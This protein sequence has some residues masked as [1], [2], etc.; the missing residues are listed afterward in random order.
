MSLERIEDDSQQRSGIR[1][2]LANEDIYVTTLEVVSSDLENGKIDPPP[3][4]E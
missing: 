2:S 1:P 4:R 3:A